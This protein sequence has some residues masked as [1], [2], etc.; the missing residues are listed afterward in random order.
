VGVGMNRLGWSWSSWTYKAVN[1]GGWALFNY[2]GD[3]YFN[4]ASATET[5]ATI[6]DKWTNRLVQWTKAGQPVNYGLNTNMIYGLSDAAA[7]V[8][9]VLKSGKS[10][11]IVNYNS[12]KA[13]A[14]GT[15]AQSQITTQKTLPVV[16]PAEFYWTA[17]QLNATQWRFTNS[18]GLAIDVEGG[19]QIDGGR[20]IQ[21]P[22]N[23]G[24]NQ[25][26]QVIPVGDGTYRIYS[27]ASLRELHVNGASLAEG[28]AINQWTDVPG[29]K[30]EHWTFVP[31]N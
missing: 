28:A 7:N 22:V 12:G 26:W 6:L 25:A 16:P 15:G 19:N 8:P 20:I 9:A 30:H 17:T 11:A 1:V 13:I 2:N 10:Y 14:A 29:A 23:N 18:L 4:T 3:L 5:Y 21:W 27:G 31:L 24:A